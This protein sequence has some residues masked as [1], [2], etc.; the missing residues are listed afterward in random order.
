V[1]FCERKNLHWLSNL[2]RDKALLPKKKEEKGKK[3]PLDT[4]NVLILYPR[5]RE[6]VFEIIFAKVLYY[7]WMLLCGA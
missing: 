4:D 3:S 1:R 6:L 2:K 7:E 5:E